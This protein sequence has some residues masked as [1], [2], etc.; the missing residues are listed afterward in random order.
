MAN[1]EPLPTFPEGSNDRP[2]RVEPDYASW[3]R[4]V[5]AFLLDG[6]LVFAVATG[7]AVATGHHD[8]PDAKSAALAL[9]PLAGNWASSLFA[10]G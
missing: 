9:R 7:I 1:F 10:L 2:S 8:V 5:V 4:R 6:A 3:I